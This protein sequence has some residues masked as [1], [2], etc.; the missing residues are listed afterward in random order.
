M[1]VITKMK[2]LLK[3]RGL[4]QKDL[5]DYIGVDKS[6]FTT[7]IKGKS[8]G[9]LKYISKIADFLG[10]SQDYL[11]DDS[12]DT[13]SLCVSK[14]I[15]AKTAEVERVASLILVE[16]I[17]NDKLLLKISEFLGCNMR[18][19][20]GIST[21]EEQEIYMSKN[22]DAE[23]IMII[24]NILDRIAVTKEYRILQVQ[25]SRWILKQL[26]K[27]DHPVTVDMLKNELK[28]STKKM[29]FINSD[30]E[31]N[32]LLTSHVGLNP[33]DLARISEKYNLDY[34]FLFTGINK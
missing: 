9:Y 16:N 19:L 24:L 25:I 14:A 21:S 27:C 3:E 32:M 6:T 15:F 23:M 12:S 28:L 18:F 29:D 17:P 20:Y 4:T 13:S 5:T 34:N 22:N 11:L 30:T 8:D 33:S 2:L 7:W 10:V 1:L 26:L 31:L